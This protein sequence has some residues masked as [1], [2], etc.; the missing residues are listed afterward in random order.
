MA[1]VEWGIDLDT[2]TLTDPRDESFISPA[3]TPA[4][5]DCLFFDVNYTAYFLFYDIFMDEFN[6]DNPVLNI[7]VFVSTDNGANWNIIWDEA[8]TAAKEGDY[9]EDNLSIDYEWYTRSLPLAGYAGQSIKIA[10]RYTDREGGDYVGL[11]N[12]AVRQG[13]GAGLRPFT[14]ATNKVV[15]KGDRF[16]LIYSPDY[17]AVSVYTISGQKLADYE[18][19][20]TGTFTVSSENYSKGVYLF[21]FTG[22]KGASTVKVVK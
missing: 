15:H 9:N 12:I 4:A 17:S 16:E 22:G 7:Q 19:P 13:I 1:F 6:F 3:F 10:I 21:S 11:D 5:D 18:L 14:V 8:E 20:P 2:F